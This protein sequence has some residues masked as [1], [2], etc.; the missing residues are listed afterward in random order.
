M[1]ATVFQITNFC[2]CS[3]LLVWRTDLDTTGVPFTVV[4]HLPEVTA[5]FF[6]TALLFLLLLLLFFQW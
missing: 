3:T 1:T 6:L 5:F 4:L 2:W